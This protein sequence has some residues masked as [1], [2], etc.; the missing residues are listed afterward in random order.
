MRQ[1]QRRHSNLL[2]ILSDFVTS[3]GKE[4]NPEVE[5]RDAVNEIQ[6]NIVPVIVSFELAPQTEGLLKLC[7]AEHPGRR[8][9]WFTRDR[10]R[11]INHEERLRVASL[12]RHFRSAGLDC[13][14]IANQRDIYPQL[15][16][17]ARVRRRRKF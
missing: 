2:F 8:L 9:A 1:D 3:N 6:Q 10:V 14:T 12:V 11:R 15:A 7:D 13:M 5:W 16:G 4:F 17:L